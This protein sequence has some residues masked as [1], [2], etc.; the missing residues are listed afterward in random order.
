MR[1]TYL[2]EEIVLFKKYIPPDGGG[3][4]AGGRWTWGNSRRTAATKDM[5]RV[6]GYATSP[7]GAGSGGCR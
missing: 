1:T 4:L 3:S 7:F 6:A 5:G 2:I